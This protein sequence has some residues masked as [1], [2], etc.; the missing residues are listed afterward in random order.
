MSRLVRPRGAL[1]VEPLE[2]RANPVSFAN[3]D[4]YGMG[5]NVMSVAVG[6]LNGDGYSDIAAGDAGNG[7]EILLNDGTGAFVRGEILPIAAPSNLKLADLNA[8]GK[9]DLFVANTWGH[10]LCAAL[11]NGDGTFQVVQTKTFSTSTQGS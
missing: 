1:V 2:D 8:D 6:D 10:R 4:S 7:V 3:G 5:G 9:L 11:G